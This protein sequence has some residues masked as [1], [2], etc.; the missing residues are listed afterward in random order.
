[1]N[2]I[3]N[4]TNNFRYSVV[5]LTHANMMLLYSYKCNYAFR[6]PFNVTTFDKFSYLDP[7]EFKIAIRNDSF[8]FIPIFFNFIYTQFNSTINR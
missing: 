1:M 7:S 3:I 2:K 4:V 5:F 8:L 6:K